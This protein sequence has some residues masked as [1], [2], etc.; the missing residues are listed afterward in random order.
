V[1]Q[2]HFAKI[3]ATEHALGVLVNPKHITNHSYKSNL[4][5]KNSFSSSLSTKLGRQSIEGYAQ[6]S[7]LSVD[8]CA[9]HERDGDAEQHAALLL[10][11]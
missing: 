2:G 6:G 3:F 9:S 10:L 4:V 7:R 1:L 8:R 5:L 11:S